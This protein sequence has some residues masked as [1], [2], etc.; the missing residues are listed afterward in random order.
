MF[1]LQAVE[2]SLLDPRML[3][4]LPMHP[5]WLVT[6][7]ARI[8][9][10]HLSLSLYCSWNQREPKVLV[11]NLVNPVIAFNLTARP[12]PIIAEQ[13][14]EP[15]APP[16]VERTRVEGEQVQP[17]A[18]IETL[19]IVSP[20]PL[21]VVQPILPSSSPSTSS[22]PRCRFINTRPRPRRLRKSRGA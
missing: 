21:P 6:L 3:L 9:S 20:P 12:R 2:T 1:L 16:T 11:G 14:S 10:V 15:I 4:A 7:Q 19:G 18:P 5:R 22:K 8:C 17:P 13:D